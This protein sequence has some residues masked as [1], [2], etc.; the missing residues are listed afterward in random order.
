MCFSIRNHCPSE[1]TQG[2]RK[3]S[4]MNPTAN[5][6][7]P[8]W[9]QSG[10][11]ALTTLLIRLPLAGRSGG[12]VTTPDEANLRAAMSGGGDVAFACDGTITLTS[13]ITNNVN[14]TLDASGHQI[15]ISGGKRVRAFHVT[16]NVSFKLVNLT[17][18][19]AVSTAGSAILNL[20][21]TVDLSGVTLRSNSA[22]FGQMSDQLV[23]QCSGGAIF[24]W[25]GIISAADCSFVGNRAQSQGAATCWFHEEVYGGAIRNHGGQ[26]E[27][28]SCVFSGNLASGGSG[29]DQL[30]CPGG[31]PG[32]P[33]LG[34]AIYNSGTAHLDLC[35]FNG[36]SA[37]GGEGMQG[38]PYP[39]AGGAAGAGS[40]GAVFN[41]G[42]MTI[43][44]SSF[45][46]NSATAGGGGAS[47]TD[48][49]TWN[50]YAGGNGAVAYGGAI[51]NSGVLSV[52]NSTVVSNRVAGGSGG[53]GGVGL[54]VSM[55]LH[56]GNG[57]RGGDAASGR[58]G[59]LF[60]TGSASLVNCTFAFNTGTGGSGGNGGAGAPSYH[61]SGD[62]GNGGNGG[63]G[64]GGVE[65]TCN[66]VNCTL[67]YNSGIAGLG[68]IG[69]SASPSDIPGVPGTNGLSG[70]E[71]GGTICTNLANTLVVSNT[72]ADGDTFAD[73]KLG[74]LA[75]N[76]GPTFTMALLAGSPAIDAAYP[77]PI[78][79]TDQRG[80]RRPVGVRAD[81]G[82]YEYAPLLS[83]SR[84]QSNGLDIL[85]RDGIPG[86]TCRLLTS[87]D[88]STWQCVTTNQIGP[89][90]T[91]LF[92][93][94]CNTSEAQRFYKAV[95][96]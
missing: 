68:G 25:N 29:C 40:G 69:G 3:E 41:L 56:G 58:G 60:N 11:Y 14:T 1:T 34:G 39:V 16:T 95:L 86:Q 70:T 52:R 92:Q 80:I 20:G 73:P 33:A 76:G 90:G 82:A 61:N 10:K 43:D 26:L 78:L 77:V 21:G 79:P 88:L 4:T 63:N 19:N 67:A 85:L 81:I 6:R 87:T 35:V 46:S 89:N 18:A 5:S 12:V 94:N 47:G 83:V 13:T 59:A 75:D 44:R 2:V 91:T 9:I 30:T 48:N 93:T 31:L 42:S 23:P 8:A 38:Y 24:S 32:D 51:R 28:R 55:E 71:R 54:L 22:V 50:G 53:A 7:N 36:N 45:W 72:P 37:K 17:I 84:S 65:G 66:L 27:L 96:P 15:T 62:G 64:F 57:A 49:V 74:L